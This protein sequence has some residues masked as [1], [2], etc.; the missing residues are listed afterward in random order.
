MTTLKAHN[1]LR[2]QAVLVKFCNGCNQDKDILEFE[3]RGGARSSH[4]RSKCKTC[5]YE[6]RDK[7]NKQKQRY[8]NTYKLEK[9]CNRCGYDNCSAALEF[10]HPNDDKW[11]SGKRAV[12]VTWSYDRINAEIAKCEVLCSNCHREHHYNN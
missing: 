12:N 7:I 8:V 2:V 5:R 9:G 3:N 6:Q 4:P 10:H 1:N 11:A